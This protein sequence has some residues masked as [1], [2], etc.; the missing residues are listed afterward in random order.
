MQLENHTNIKK[1]NDLRMLDTS[2]PGQIGTCVFSLILCT[3]YPDHADSNPDP[4]S[5]IDEKKR[6]I[7]FVFLVM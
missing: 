2:V 6:L 1:V 5:V 7:L 3:V 4:R